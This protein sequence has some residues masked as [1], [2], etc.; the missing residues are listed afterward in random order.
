MAARTPSQIVKTAGREG[1]YFFFILGMSAEADERGV[2]SLSTNGTECTAKT[3]R[4]PVLFDVGVVVW[5]CGVDGF[6]RRAP[7]SAVLYK[8]GE[9]LT[10][11]KTQ[12]PLWFPLP[13]NAHDFTGLS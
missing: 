3:R 6:V 13:P 11:R 10:R 7:V 2:P 9:F 8:I 4:V 12:H 5:W 1:E